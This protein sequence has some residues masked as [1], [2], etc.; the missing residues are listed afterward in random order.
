MF[1]ISERIG[2]KRQHRRSK[3]WGKP[4]SSRTEILESVSNGICRESMFI[5]DDRLQLSTAKCKDRVQSAF[6]FLSNGNNR[7]EA[8]CARLRRPR[9][10]WPKMVMIC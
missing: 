3:H 1:G 8:N 6:Y 10:S 7:A 4:Q 9:S 5:Q 2:I